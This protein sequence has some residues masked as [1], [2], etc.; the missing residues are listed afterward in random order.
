MVLTPRRHIR[1]LGTWS[2]RHFIGDYNITTGQPS[3]RTS[4]CQSPEPYRKGIRNTVLEV[5]LREHIQT[6]RVIQTVLCAYQDGHRAG[7]N[8]ARF[9]QTEPYSGLQKTKIIASHGTSGKYNRQPS[10]GN[11]SHTDSPDEE[12]WRNGQIRSV[13][14]VS[15][16]IRLNPSWGLKCYSKDGER[17]G[18][19]LGVAFLGPSALLFYT[20]LPIL[21]S[22]LHSTTT[23][24]NFASA[25]CDKTW[26]RHIGSYAGVKKPGTSC[27]EMK[28]SFLRQST[29]LAPPCPFPR[30]SFRYKL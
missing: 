15:F 23:F 4:V 21:I 8:D 7:W 28:N 11:F 10:M 22:G 27:P 24:Y 12:G 20:F 9:W 5:R 25:T 3:K 29:E 19:S 16:L 1:I 26:L 30:S 6:Q 18:W 13:L 14:C 2:S 17:E